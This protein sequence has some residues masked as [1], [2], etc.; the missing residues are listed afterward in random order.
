V[1][2][3]FDPALDVVLAA[4]EG[5]TTMGHLT[6]RASVGALSVA[7]ILVALA[8]SATAAARPSTVESGA[9]PSMTAQVTGAPT[10]VVE[11][12]SARPNGV[13]LEGTTIHSPGH[14]YELLQPVELELQGNMISV[15]KGSIF[16]LTCYKRCRPST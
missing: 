11:Y 5:K 13:Q 15:S 8:G 16:K 4:S 1:N 9:C 10:A 14:F 6:I 12:S 2:E 7:A 3:G